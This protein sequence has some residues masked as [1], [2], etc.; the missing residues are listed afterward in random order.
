MTPTR[1]NLRR[2]LPIRSLKSHSLL[3][4]GNGLAGVETL[5]AG[6]CAVE[7]R[8]ATVQA[9]GV[10]EGGLTLSLALVTGVGQPAVG[11]KEDGGSEVLLRVPPVRGAGSRAAGA[12]NALVETRQ[13]LS[14]GDAL[15]VLLALRRVSVNL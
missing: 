6:T 5:G 4:L 14:V 11:L 12:E 8:V 13:L 3:D 1:R 15:A 7:N 10:V 9:H 2:Q